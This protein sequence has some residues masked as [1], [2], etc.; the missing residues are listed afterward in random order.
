MSDRAPST[1]LS[2]SRR[3]AN[4][5]LPTTP[6]G[7]GG[8]GESVMTEEH[9]RYNRPPQPRGRSSEPEPLGDL[10]R[11]YV[12]ARRWHHLLA[13]ST[14]NGHRPADPTTVRRRD[15]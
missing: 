7:I 11:R 5:S 13:P 2:Q 9:G 4:N 3:P 1:R 14:A 8:E 6:P 10:L 12:E 15:G